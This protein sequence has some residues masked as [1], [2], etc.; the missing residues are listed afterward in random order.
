MKPEK[1]QIMWKTRKPDIISELDDA[2]SDITE[3]QYWLFTEVLLEYSKK[4]ELEC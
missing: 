1:M 3:M 4:V 2:V